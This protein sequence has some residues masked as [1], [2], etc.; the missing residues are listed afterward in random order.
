MS[1]SLTRRPRRAGDDDGF[2]LVEILVALTLFALFSAAALPLVV[3]GLRAGTVAKLDTGAKNLTQE[4]FEKLR[5]LPFHTP[6]SANG[7]ADLLDKYFPNVVAAAGT[8]VGGYVSAT[9]ARRPGEPTGPL[10]RTIITAAE[11]SP[12][13]A[14][15]GTFNRYTQSVA[16]QFL[17]STGQPFAPA[18]WN[19][20][21]SPDDEELPSLIARA[22]VTTTWTAGALSKR[23]TVST[24][25]T[26]GRAIP[27]I[28]R[29]ELR[30]TAVRIGSV[31]RDALGTVSDL[32]LEAGGI[33]ADGQ[34]ARGAK[35]AGSG[36][37]AFASLVPGARVDGAGSGT[38]APTDKA[39]PAATLGTVQLK[40]P[41]G[42]PLARVGQSEV[43]TFPM[44]AASGQFQAGTSV[45]PV[46][47]TAKASGEINFTN[48]PLL[49]PVLTTLL[50]LKPDA[51]V[52]TTL[53]T[54]TP[55]AR[56][57]GHTVSTGGSTHSVLATATLSSP[58]LAI[59]PTNFAPE[60]I[61]QVQLDASTITC[62][63]GMGAVAPTLTYSGSFRYWRPL[64]GVEGYS[65][66]VALNET[67]TADALN[68]LLTKDSFGQTQIVHMGPTG[69]VT[70]SDYFSSLSSATA[71]SL[72]G[73]RLVAPP[74]YEASHPSLIQLSTVSLRTDIESPVTIALGAASCRAEDRR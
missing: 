44:A 4:R 42:V 15:A 71:S 62:T 51:P 36:R 26:Q 56:S 29:A 38:A 25:I 2:S 43:A 13:A 69:A 23:Y 39:A 65:A 45:N 10:Y 20:L 21:V 34:V 41:L 24:E 61:I 40:D 32:L 37:G 27:P 6:R 66:P 59:L 5:N 9:A 14:T 46:N 70:Y 7:G 30:A 73:Q 50:D 18:A 8:A 31:Y 3:T 22:T 16:T 60:G 67:A 57:A 64:N 11:I 53:T 52:V 58:T 48:R 68:A 47:A 54:G 49:G 12:D 17:S 55:T 28:A 33:T 35:V 19:S 72:S 1:R 74:R 63:A